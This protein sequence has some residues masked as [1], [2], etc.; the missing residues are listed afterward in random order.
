MKTSE[1]QFEIIGCE[2]YILACSHARRTHVHPVLGLYESLVKAH[3][4][5]DGPV[6]EDSLLLVVDWRLRRPQ[7][8][9]V[10]LVLFSFLK[11][12]DTVHILLKLI[13]NINV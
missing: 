13:I 11:G 7:A 3:G 5:E 1:I 2:I 8:L 9:L 4:V 6:L 10:G 12:K